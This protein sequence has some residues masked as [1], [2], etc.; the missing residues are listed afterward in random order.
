MAHGGRAACIAVHCGPGN[1]D[2]PL[3]RR[4]AAVHATQWPLRRTPWTACG[5]T[6]QV[7]G[8]VAIMRA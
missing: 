6:P 3:H 5:F 1:L 7:H 8:I 4:D 2:P